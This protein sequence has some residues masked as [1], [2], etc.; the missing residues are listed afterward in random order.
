[1][2][3]NALQYHNLTSYQRNEIPQHF[4]DWKNQPSTFKIYPGIELIRLPKVDQLGEDNL[5]DVFKGCHGM[6][7]KRVPDITDLSKILLM[8]YTITAKSAHGDG[9][10]YYR[11]VASAGALY[12]TEIYV[13]TH[14]VK[15]VKD[16]LYHFSIAGHA[17]VPLRGGNVSEFVID[18]LFNTPEKY[19]SLTFFFTAIFFRS[20]WK[21]RERAYR[22]HLLDTGHLIA[23]ME[24]ALHLQDFPFHLLLDFADLKM[25]WLLGLDQDREVTL[26]ICYI[27]GTEIVPHE[28]T[29]KQSEELET[30][31]K[32]AGSVSNKETRYPAIQDIHRAGMI[33]VSVSQAGSTLPKST[34]KTGLKNIEIEAPGAW[35]EILNAK[36]TLCHRRS[37]RNFIPT[38]LSDLCFSSLLECLD[39][40]GVEAVS[41]PGDLTTFP[42]MA[43][44][45]ANVVGLEPGIYFRDG[46][47]HSLQLTTEG[48]FAESMARICLDQ[49]WMANAAVHFLFIGELGDVDTFQGPRG[50]RYLMIK[51]GLLGEKLYLAATAMGLGCC[52]IGAF[53]DGEAS[54]LLALKEGARLLYL[55]AL[56]PVKSI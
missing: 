22:Y 47:T 50:Y 19:P 52:G 49:M 1:M 35:P 44:I 34:V 16:G 36:E 20:S 21:Y 9:Y 5:S 40:G 37:R 13:A 2:N 10:Q 31:S 48:L 38:P 14:A 25:N 30:T 26:A 18:A 45:V 42:H 53:Y 41:S 15:G 6:E 43:F 54:Q 55:I 17:L 7:D 8:A 3:I 39:V 33:Q 24:V 23:N 51:A 32:E 28:D 27:P 46:S 4:L 12:P 29:E 11:S 56:G